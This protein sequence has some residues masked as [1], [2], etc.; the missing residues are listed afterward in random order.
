MKV[1]AIFQ[2]LQETH[3][4]DKL[5]CE[6]KIMFIG[7]NPT[8][9]YLK[10]FFSVHKQLDEN[11]YYNWQPIKQ[12]E[13]IFNPEKLINYRAIVVASV[14]NEH[15]I[16]D[17]INDWV[18]ASKIDISVLKLFTNIFINFMSG[19]KLLQ[20]TEC[21]PSSPRLSYAIITTPRSG[22]TFLCSILQ[23]IR[24][25]GYPTEHLR[26]ASAILANNCQF[27]YIKLLHALMAYKTTPNGVFGTKFISHFLEVFQKAEF[28]FGE[29]FQSISKYIYLV[30]QDKV[31]QAVSIV[32]AQKTN[33]WH[34]S[35]QEKQQNYETQLE[36]IEIEE[37]L[38]KEVHKQYR[39]IQQQ[40]EYLIKLFETYHISPLIVEYEQL[41]EHTEEQTN[42]ILDYLQIPPLETKTTNLKSHLRKMRS[43]LS[44]QIIKE[45]KD[46]FA[47]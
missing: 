18:D 39:F 25:A 11:Y 38:L 24:I 45:Y 1:E 6:E 46:K 42:L 10:K 8:I 30:R 29:I 43:D 47:H 34:I 27:D 14:N 32:L 16:F 19:Q 5:I 20:V 3:F 7:E 12:Q 41:V 31:A 40:E 13:L 26:Q 9:S 28:D 15:A 33:V 35:T 4:L 37:F 2:D 22:S 36:Q 44:E 23:S 17:E 21:R